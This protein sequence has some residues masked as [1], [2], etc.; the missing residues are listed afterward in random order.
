MRCHVRKSRQ[1]RRRSLQRRQYARYPPWTLDEAIN[2][3]L[4]WILACLAVAPPR[5]LPLWPSDERPTL[6]YTDASEEHKRLHPYIIGAVIDSP[7]AASLLY[8]MCP[9][10]PAFIATWLPKKTH[11]GQLEIFAGVVALDTWPELVGDSYLLHFRDNDSA[12]ACLIAGYSA[13]VDS[14]KIVGE[15]WLRRAKH[16]CFVYVN[17]VETHSNI[18]DGPSRLDPSEVVALGAQF[19]EPCTDLFSSSPPSD[20]PFHWFALPSL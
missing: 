20:D 15:Y 9:V 17:R 6:L 1:N 14:T 13:K 7:R 5:E 4:G 2:A 18:S 3:C 8:T 12:T 10:P 16:K 11:I 19:T